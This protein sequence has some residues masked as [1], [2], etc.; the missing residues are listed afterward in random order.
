VRRLVG[1][2]NTINRLI[3]TPD[4][5]WLISA[6]SDHTVRYWDLDAPAKGAEPL[7]LNGRALEEAK[8]RKRK[9]PAPIEATVAVQEAAKVLDA[10]REWV[11][12]LSLSHDGNTLL[13]GD[14]K[15]EVI[16]WDRGA[17]KEQRRLHIKGWVYG[18]ALAPDASSLV[19]AER[20][21]RVF[22]SGRHAGVKIWDPVKAT[23]RHD[24]SKLFKDQMIA[25]AAYSPN[26]NVLA[27]ARGGEID[28]PKG[29]ITLLDPATGQKLRELS[30]GHL[31]GATDV[32]FH[33]DGKV[34]YSAGRDTV[35]RAWCVEDGKL[36]EE[37]GKPRGGQFKDWIHAVSVSP[38]GRRL[39]AADMAGQVQVWALAK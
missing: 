28:G 24:L 25:A 37:L 21:P 29:T 35:V 10:H 2:T 12:G 30:P 16:I 17:G 23:V 14:D 13:T 15:G 20:L 3:A 8:K 11:L 32:A 27:V 34:L 38:D 19:I 6:S 36:L 9:V 26:G 22:D 39:A 4:G 7:V 31:N 33:P 1:H 5:R 18:M